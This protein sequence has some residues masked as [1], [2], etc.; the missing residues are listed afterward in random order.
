MNSMD[1]CLEL[2]AGSAAIGLTLAERVYINDTSQPLIQFYTD[3]VVDL[4]GTVQRAKLLQAEINN[5][6]DPKAAFYDLRDKFNLGKRTDSAVFLTLLYS[7]FN[8]LWRVNRSG[9]CNIP[10]GGKRMLPE[11]HILALPVAKIRSVTCLD[12]SQALEKRPDDKVVVFADPPYE[13]RFT[14]YSKKQ[15]SEEDSDNLLS[16]LSKI[17][18]PVVV[19]FESKR[20]EEYAQQLGFKTGRCSLTYLNGA[21][22]KVD[23]Q[24]VICYNEAGRQYVKVDKLES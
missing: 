19:T 24:E 14:S 4:S 3:A 20:M 18:N 5:S 13:G 12:W 7:G 1:A 22:T 17:D 8:G 16:K 21:R 11:Q 15:W 9:K 10:Y 23:V 2:F 6:V